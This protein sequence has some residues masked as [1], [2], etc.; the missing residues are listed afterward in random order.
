MNWAD[1][2][3]TQRAAM[4]AE[5]ASR[6][7]HPMVDWMVHERGKRLDDYLAVHWVIVLVVSKDY[8]LDVLA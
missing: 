8:L 2:T 7:V 1:L 5:L 4:W 3:A 6:K